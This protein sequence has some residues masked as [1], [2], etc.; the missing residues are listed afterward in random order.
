MPSHYFTWVTSDV[1]F[2]VFNIDVIDFQRNVTSNFW[3]IS[4]GLFNFSTPNIDKSN[5]GLFHKYA[6]AEIMLNFTMNTWT[7]LSN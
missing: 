6:M 1:S 4:C 2:L 5:F 3:G 7:A